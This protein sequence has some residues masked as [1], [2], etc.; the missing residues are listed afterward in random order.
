MLACSPA[1][2]FND[3]LLHI[4]DEKANLLT[5]SGPIDLLYQIT[6]YVKINPLTLPHN[7]DIPTKRLPCSHM[8]LSE[9]ST[10]FQFL[11]NVTKDHYYTRRDMLF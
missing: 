11:K 6:H 5:Q 4:K 9:K 1:L 8:I 2:I 10:A 3:S 7:P